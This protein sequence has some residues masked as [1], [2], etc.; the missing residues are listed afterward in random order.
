MRNDRRDHAGLAFN[1]EASAGRS[2]VLWT[3]A[4]S[5]SFDSPRASVAP[6]ITDGDFAAIASDLDVWDAWPIQHPDGN[7]V[8]VGGGAVLWMALGAPHF[9]DPDLRHGHARIHLLQHYRGTWTNLGPTMPDGFSPGSREWSGSAVLEAQ[10]GELTLY[11]TATG[12]RGEALLTFEQ[13][14]FRARATLS[15]AGQA[16]LENWRDLAEIA[17]RDP[18]HYMASDYGTGTIGTIKA[19]RDPAFFRDPQD[20]SRHLLFAA[21][22]AHSR[23]DYNGVVGLATATDEALDSWQ[24][25]PPIVSADGLNNELERPHAIYHAGLYYLF[26]STQRHVFN[27]AGPT[28]PTGLYG[29]VADRLRGDWRPLNGTGLVF[30]NPDEAP[31]QAY[32]WLVMP[33]L[34][35]TSFVDDWGSAVSKSGRNFGATFAPMLSLVLDGDTVRLVDAGTKNTA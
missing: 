5:G 20:G 24:V 33:D 13:R 26:W 30:R 15:L 14:L 12:R 10:T 16:Q 34:A 31:A 18:A 32:S 1:R 17:V 29:M 23:S 22:A 6:L 7:P 28:G 8:D 27:P 4:H 35:V 25:L 11:F 21:S 19:Y 9:S 3:V 2:P